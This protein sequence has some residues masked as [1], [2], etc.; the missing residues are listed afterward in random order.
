MLRDERLVVR[1]HDRELEP[2]PFGIL[3]AESTLGPLGRVES[4]LPEVERLFRADPPD[5][6][7]HH[8]G[9]RMAAPR[10]GILEERDVRAGASLLVRVEEVIDGR[11]VLVDRLLDES[12]AEHAGVEV[13]VAWR[14]GGDQRDVVDTFQ[15]HERILTTCIDSLRR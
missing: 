2:H 10:A 4:L 7:V 1:L 11:I 9:A 14:V 3:E 8:A 5:D 6:R 13:D 15:P 12:Q